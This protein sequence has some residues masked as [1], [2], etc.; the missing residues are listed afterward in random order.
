MDDKLHLMDDQMKWVLQM[1]SVGK[2][3]MKVIERTTK[4]VRYYMY[5]VDKAAA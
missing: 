1:E 4:V 2:D 5:L 3:A